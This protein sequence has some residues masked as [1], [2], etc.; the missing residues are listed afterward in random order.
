MRAASDDHSVEGFGRPGAGRRRGRRARRWPRSAPAVLMLAARSPATAL[1]LTAATRGV[2]IARSVP[3]ATGVRRTLDVYRPRDARAAPVIVFFYGGSWQSG[4]KSI[5]K[6][7][8]SALARRGYVVVIPD[9]RVYPEVVYPGFLE[10][11]ALA[12]RW[13]RDN[14]E[15]FGGNPNILFLMGHSAGAYIAAMLALDGRWLEHVGLL[16]NRDIAGLVGIS[17]PYDFLP[18]RDQTLKTIFGSANDATTQPIAHVALGAPS[19]LLL[20]GL[21]DGTVD[22]GNSARLAVRL[23]GVGVE[24]TAMTYS[25]VG[26]LGIVGA[27]AAPLR[28]LAPVLRDVDRFVS[29]VSTEALPVTDSTVTGA[30]TV[31]K[32]LQ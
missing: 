14:A 21:K 16:P 25:W 32:A 2:A 28:L 26:H 19:A 30:S 24:A 27:F 11:G 20:T 23:R 29:G 15:R 1:N 31:T 8:G 12:L 6:F 5:Y 7:V 9:Y 10:D 3:Y 22:P 18:L 4:S 13:T 17:G